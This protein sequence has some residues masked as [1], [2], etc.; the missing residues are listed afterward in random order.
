MINQSLERALIEN[1]WRDPEFCR[2]IETDPK[3]ALKSLGVEVPDGVKLNMRMQRRD[4]LYFV[5]PPL[6]EHPEDT[7]KVIN[8]MDLWQS[9][10]LFCWIM[11]QALK[12]EL[13]AMRQGYRKAHP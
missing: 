5:I 6:A 3:A 7:N 13:L 9:A 10:D 4:T 11:P 2:L 1:A 8:Q 12:L